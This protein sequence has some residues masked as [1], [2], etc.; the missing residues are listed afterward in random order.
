MKVTQPD[1]RSIRIVSDSGIRLSVP[2]HFFWNG[3]ERPAESI[4]LDPVKGSPGAWEVRAFFLFGEIRDRLREDSAGVV[5]SRTW[6]VKTPGSVHLCIDF[7]VDPTGDLAWMVP[8]V[9]AARGMPSRPVSFLAERGAYPA[10]VFV[11]LGRKSFLLFS[12]SARCGEED[13][14]IGV[15]R[16]EVEDE[17]HRLHL[18]LRFPG[19]E[20][21]S[22]RTGPR[23]RDQEP[24][25]EDAIESP[26][27]LELTHEACL[28]FA[29]RDRVTVHGPA[30]VLQRIPLSD[31][32]P[33][34]AGA[35][36]LVDAL[37]HVLDRHLVQASAVA[38]LR[39][40]PD[41][42][43]ISASAGLGFAL[44][45]R[46]LLPDDPKMIELGLRLADF[47]LKGQVPWGLFYESYHLPSGS[48]RGVRGI[49][50]RTVL[51]V[52][53]SARI[54]ELL[55]A[56]ADDLAAGGQPNEKYFLAGLRL[57]DYFLDDKG[58]L[59]QPGG[60]HLPSAGPAPAESNP[61]LAGMELFFPLARVL[62]RTGRDR[63]KKAMD[64]LVRR[65]SAL[66]WD[67]FQPPSS[68]EHRGSDSAA[69]LLAAR[70]FLHMRGLG[71]KPT[72]PPV[73]GAAAAR[74]KAAESVRLFS[75][76][77]V[78][79]IRVQAGSHSGYLLDSFERQRLL[80]AGNQAALLL[81]GLAAVTSDT[82]EKKL[83]VALA[84]DCARHRGN[85]PLG[86][87]FIQHTRWDAA[88]EMPAGKKGG[89]APDAKK[90]PVRRANPYRVGPV[91][92]RRVAT[93]VLAAIEL[94]REFPGA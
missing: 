10:G 86:A 26:G 44:A 70:L 43:W 45:L 24:A 54:A 55:L 23:P 64:Q 37:R 52:G 13:G 57:V 14:S 41:S 53:Q 89:R 85:I 78:P 66:P 67:P 33:A 8:G 18:Q 27:A 11:G 47:A 68:R 12:P 48:W 4:A 42:P 92:S 59:V 94:E 82:V 25:E 5:L 72:E 69:A 76:L 39:E 46:T 2:Y 74:A 34:G 30:S 35:P 20:E 9:Q 61:G 1:S 79:W 73:T 28:V 88:G 56:L 60:L 19:I 16:T 49:T 75:S 63:Y 6:S 91:D 15:W 40:L 3:H 21:P 58:K 90:R 17:P 51:S 7:E 80:C 62:A 31:E 29:D 65:F 84:R 32:R 77:L 71:Y 93:E 22:G 50:D 36:V 81:R 38:G 83:L 87:S